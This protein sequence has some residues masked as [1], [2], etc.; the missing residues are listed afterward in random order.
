MTKTELL[1]AVAT[2]QAGLFEMLSLDQG[3]VERLRNLRG[4]LENAKADI[5]EY[6]AD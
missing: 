2:V 5:R 4:E 6:F 1:K 3:D